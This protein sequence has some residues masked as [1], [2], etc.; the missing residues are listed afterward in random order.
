MSEPQQALVED[1]RRRSK[2]RK[3]CER[4]DLVCGERFFHGKEW[5]IQFAQVL[6]SVG[7]SWERVVE[8]CADSYGIG[9]IA[10]VQLLKSLAV[11]ADIAG[12]FDLEVGESKLAVLFD[13]RANPFKLATPDHR[14]VAVFPG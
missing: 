14:G 2:F 6:G 5:Y 9:S 7:L 3:P 12:E 4:G 11:A 10:G 13:C 8:V 1:D